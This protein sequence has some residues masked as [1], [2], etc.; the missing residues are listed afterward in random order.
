MKVKV[1]LRGTLSNIA[2]PEKEVFLPEDACVTD[3]L[4]FLVKQYGEVFGNKIKHPE[5]WQISINGHLHI[6]PAATGTKLK[7]QDEVIILP[8]I[9]G[10]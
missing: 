7:N 6:L 10:G 4:D 3:L 9:F 5:M 1:F 2:V 8:L